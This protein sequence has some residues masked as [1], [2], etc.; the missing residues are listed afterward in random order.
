MLYCIYRLS[1]NKFHKAR[2]RKAYYNTP[3]PDKPEFLIMNYELRI[4][5]AKIN[6]NL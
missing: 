1:D 5:A 4:Q 3:N 6:F 2:G